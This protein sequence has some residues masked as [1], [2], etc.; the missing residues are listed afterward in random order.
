MSIRQAVKRTFDYVFLALVS[1]AAFLCWLERVTTHD[2][3]M[4]FSFWAQSFAL[5]P[6]PPG[7]FIR[8]AFYTWTLESCSSSF[9]IGFG[10]LFTHRHAIVD[11]GAYVGAYALIGSAHLGADCLVGSR[12][13][14]LSG[15]NLHAFKDGRWEPTDLSRRQQIQIGA[16]CWI[17]EGAIVVADVGAS[18]VVSTGAVVTTAV[19]PAVV[20]AGN[21]AR[22][23][24]RLTPDAEPAP[25][26]AG[27][28][29]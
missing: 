21:P 2:G 20:M 27:A 18:A 14:I 8:R 3:E 24:R 10:A 5:V 13:S 9:Y 12:A 26:E 1:P 25:S 15:P 22:F 6:G 19:P 11:H 4:M 23:V 16:H 28:S 29:R 17:G 7:I